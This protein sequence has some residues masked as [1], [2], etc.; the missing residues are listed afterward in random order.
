MFA[1]TWSVSGRVVE[2][3]EAEH[4]EDDRSPGD[5]AQQLEATHSSP[6]HGCEGQDHRSPND[7]HKPERA[8]L[9]C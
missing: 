2:E 4:Q 8:V 6:L 1:P 7:E 3:A 9:D 5:F